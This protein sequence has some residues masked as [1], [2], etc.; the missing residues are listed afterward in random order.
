M[1]SSV[2]CNLNHFDSII[3]QENKRP[4]VSFVFE[5]SKGFSK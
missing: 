5:T 4:D 1:I 2:M 3:I